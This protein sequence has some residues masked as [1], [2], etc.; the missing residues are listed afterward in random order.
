ML[1]KPELKDSAFISEIKCLHHYEFQTK[2]YIESAKSVAKGFHIKIKN[3][4]NFSEAEFFI[5]ESF[6][7]PEN[8]LDGKSNDLMIGKTVIN[9]DSKMIGTVISI[10][11][12][13]SYDIIEIILENDISVFIPMTK[14]FVSIDKGTI[15]LLREL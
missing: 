11:Q 13:P 9:I 6:A 1:F 7:L 12:T 5:G 10:S 2:W 4:N 15:R 3:V 14:E 8:E